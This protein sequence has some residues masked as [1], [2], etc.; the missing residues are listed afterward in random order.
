MCL[1]LLLQ[2]DQDPR[3]GSL[4]DNILRSEGWLTRLTLG[5]DLDAVYGGN[6]DP[7]LAEFYDLNDLRHLDTRG[8]WHVEPNDCHFLTELQHLTTLELAQN[9][10]VREPLLLP[11]M[12]NCPC[13]SIPNQVCL[14]LA[15]HLAHRRVPIR[16]V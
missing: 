6:K 10:E 7:V 15:L 1:W 5:D 8:M 16:A 12:L 3:R 14:L 13:C 2:L 9:G 4:L 11:L